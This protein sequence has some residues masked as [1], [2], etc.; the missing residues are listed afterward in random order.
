MTTLQEIY[1]HRLVAIIRG[2]PGA[3]IMNVVEALYQGGIRIIEITV[4]TPNVFQW[5]AKV[6][7]IYQDQIVVGAGTVLDA[8]T[9]R[10]AIM[11]G[12][13]F[14]LSPTVDKET[15]AIT[16]RY[17]AVSI[18]GAMTPTEIL[19]AFESGGDIIKVFPATVLGP[20]YLKDIKGPLPQ[21]PVMPTGGVDVDNIS[22]YFAVGAVAAGIGSSLV[23]KQ[24]RYSEQDLQALTESAKSF[25]HQRD[26]ASR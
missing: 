11:A 3:E 15:I 4:D 21:I 17:G 18:P 2:V 13:Q 20:G 22:E 23:K 8:E 14:I 19:T 1:T 25:C 6:R 7:E 24:S 16:K 9:A 10:A 5:I 26:I 12:A